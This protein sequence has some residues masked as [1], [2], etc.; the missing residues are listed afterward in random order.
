MG[1]FDFFCSCVSDEDCSSA[2][3][4]CMDLADQCDGADQSID[5]YADCMADACFWADMECKDE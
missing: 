5:V 4:D 2:H 3:E 1:I